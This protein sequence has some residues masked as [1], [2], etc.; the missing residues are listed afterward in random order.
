MRY[1]IEPRDYDDNRL[2][3]NLDWHNNIIMKYEIIINLLG[4][5][6]NKLSNFTTKIWISINNHSAGPYNTDSHISF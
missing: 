4:N 2:M 6:S 5:T 1:L 3:M